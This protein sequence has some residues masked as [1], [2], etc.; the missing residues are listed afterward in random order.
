MLRREVR[1]IRGER[2]GDESHLSATAACWCKAE[3]PCSGIRCGEA[4]RKPIDT[5]AQSLDWAA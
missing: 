2:E 4:M 3:E 1:G 5:A